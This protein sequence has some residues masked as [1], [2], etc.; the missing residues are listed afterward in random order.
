MMRETQERINKIE[1]TINLLEDHLHKYGH[2][3]QPRPFRFIKSQIKYYKRELQ[4][5]RDYPI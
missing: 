1:L 3:I 4:I 5:R 2:L